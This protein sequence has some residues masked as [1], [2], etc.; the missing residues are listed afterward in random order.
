MAKR[1]EKIDL[2]KKNLTF[3]FQKIEYK[4][5]RLCQEKMVIEI[6]PLTPSE[7]VLREIPFAHLSKELKKII[8]PN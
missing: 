5:L 2:S 3:T 6:S 4:L 8:K 1:K 7:D